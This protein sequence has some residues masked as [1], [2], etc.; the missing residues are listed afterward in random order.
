MGNGP[1]H[2]YTSTQWVPTSQDG[3]QVQEAITVPGLTK[4]ELFAAMAL[5]GICAS[6]DRE[7]GAFRQNI[8][9][10]AVCAVRSA[11]ALLDELEKTK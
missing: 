11:D 6:H 3:V 10:M 7:D 2:P 1:V 5:Q 8:D 4:R 9:A